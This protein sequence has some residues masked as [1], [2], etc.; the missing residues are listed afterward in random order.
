MIPSCLK[1]RSQGQ[2][3]NVQ[4]SYRRVISYQCPQN[5]IVQQDKFQLVS[6]LNHSVSTGVKKSTPPLD[7]I[8]KKMDIIRYFDIIIVFIIFSSSHKI[9]YTHYHCF[10]FSRNYLYILSL[11]MTTRNLTLLSVQI[12]FCYLLFNDTTRIILQ[13]IADLNNFKEDTIR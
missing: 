4:S 10:L 5:S 9:I 8:H 6:P 3:A 13:S 11:Y 7:L 2:L 1:I 12:D